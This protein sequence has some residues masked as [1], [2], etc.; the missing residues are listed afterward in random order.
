MML[1]LSAFPC[2][3]GYLGAPGSLVE[4]AGCERLCREE[5]LTTAW[6]GGFNNPPER[7]ARDDWQ[8]AQDYRRRVLVAARG[9]TRALPAP[10]LFSP[11]A[12]A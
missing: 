8:E 5:W 10:R 11:R 9:A 1:P 6:C 2:V 4:A 7:A 3:F 12:A